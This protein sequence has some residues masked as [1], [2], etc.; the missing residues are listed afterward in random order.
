MITCGIE[1]SDVDHIV[2]RI[3]KL[4]LDEEAHVRPEIDPPTCP[5]AFKFLL[6]GSA[7]NTSVLGK[8]EGLEMSLAAS[9]VSE[10]PSTIMRHLNVGHRI[11][12][13]PECSYPILFD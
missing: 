4:Q 12:S 2:F 11:E 9:P 8:A 3:E 5:T 13:V 6:V 10:Q 7:E 1:L